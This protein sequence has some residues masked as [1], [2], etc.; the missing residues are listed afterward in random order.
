MA[1]VRRISEQNRCRFAPAFIFAG[2]R[3]PL[4]SNVKGAHFANPH[5]IQAAAL[6]LPAFPVLVRN[7][8]NQNGGKVN[9]KLQ[10]QRLRAE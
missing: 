8:K 5:P 6:P 4:H 10:R 3:A 1:G 7:P 2:L 9:E